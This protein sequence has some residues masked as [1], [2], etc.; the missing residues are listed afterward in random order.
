MR[1]AQGLA[2]VLPQF[3]FNRLRTALIRAANV[4][5]G[6]GSLLMGDVILS[7]SG[8]WSALLSVGKE[9]Y[10]T[11]PLRIDLGGAVRIGNGVNI[12]HDCLLLTVDHNIGPAWRRAGA[13][14]YAPIVIED[15]AWLASRVT[16]LPGVTIGSGSIVAAGSV[17]TSP[18]APNT[19][20]G[21]VPAKL[22]RKLASSEPCEVRTP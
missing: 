5:I 8:D 20:V 19:L 16:I 3:C 12:G 11:G 21:G 6:E 14:T 22:L 1:L 7:G 9:T 4:Q 13:L 18:V 2:R 17:V 10:I 15:G